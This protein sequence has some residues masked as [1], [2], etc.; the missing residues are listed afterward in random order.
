MVAST[1]GLFHICIGLQFL[2]LVLLDQKFFS[3]L[4]ERIR[5]TEKKNKKKTTKFGQILSPSVGLRKI[6][7]SVCKTKFTA[8]GQVTFSTQ[9]RSKLKLFIQIYKISLVNA[10]PLETPSI[11]KNKKQHEKECYKQM[12]V[13]EQNG[14][15]FIKIFK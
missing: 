8:I 12:D 11:T 3:A 15:G 9:Q 1:A 10:K 14:V 6:K 4:K 2:L 13:E 7:V 5:K